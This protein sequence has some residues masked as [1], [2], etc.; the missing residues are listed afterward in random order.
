MSHRQSRW[1]NNSNNQFKHLELSTNHNSKKTLTNKKQHMHNAKLQ[2]LT[3]K[4]NRFL[5]FKQKKKKPTNTSNTK[6]SDSEP[7]I[8]LHK[9]K[10][11]TNF[12]YSLY[13]FSRYSSQLGNTK[14]QNI[15][16]K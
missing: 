9:P 3:Y 11:A 14:T 1:Q 13:I 12:N 15:I 6:K 7:S 2:K 8:I 16:F 4:T 10:Q 5:I